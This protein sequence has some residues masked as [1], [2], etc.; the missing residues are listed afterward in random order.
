MGRT[1]LG[2]ELG[3]T[4]IKAVAVDEGFSPVAAG[5]Y[6]WQSKLRD[7]I[8]T[9]DLPEA[10]EGLAAAIRNAGDL[11][12]V[13]SAGVSGMMHGY[14][15]FDADWRQL[16]PFRTWQNTVTGEAAARLT[17]LFGFNI[18]Q[19]WSVAHLL[20]AL[21]N[22][23]EHVPRVAHIT[24]LAGYIHHLLTG[25]NAVGIGEASGMFPVDR[26]TGDYDAR[27]IRL[28]DRLAE[29]LGAPWR[30]KDLLPEVLT[31]GGDAG[32]L[33]PEGS[34]LLGGTLPAGLP[35]APPEGDAGTG[36]VA[37]NSVKPRTGNVSAG[38]SVFSMV[39]LEKPL[40]RVYPEIDIVATPAGREVAMA[41]C[42]NGTLDSDAW[43][44]VFREAAGLFG[45]APSGGELY[46]ALYR[47]ALKGEP[48]CGGVC[49]CNYVAGE[50]ITH[51]DSGRPLVLRRPGARLTLA[52]FMRASLYSVL[53][54][55]KTG[56]D[57]LSGEGA[58]VDTLTG[59]GGFFKTPGVGQ[60]FLAAACGTNVTCR[61]SAGE[62]G[63]YG[64][65]LLAA[66]R[67]LKSPGETLE[68]FLDAVFAGSPAAVVSPDPGDVAGFSRY[69]ENYRSLLRVERAA[70]EAI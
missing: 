55:L 45:A 34:A 67:A 54:T 10:V 36:M 70:V 32:R 42:N 60:R 13:A 49:V 58:A 11:G 3:S 37:T 25:V 17:G 19:R 50:G 18:P 38:T 68:S 1:F 62:G 43:A 21:L 8:W 40:S 15:A 5:E 27:M 46:T 69:M 20:Q 65:A 39:V 63:P 47:E 9:Y 48:D 7:G 14:L 64:M 51:L 33:T 56:M 53:A 31:A 22:G 59:H 66:Y 30:V 61:S 12:D 24:T 29:E 4:R 44:G 23:E 28:F 57:I 35:F 52:N 26:S 2:V 41:H 16:V 6:V